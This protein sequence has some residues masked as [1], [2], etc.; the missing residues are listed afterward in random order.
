MTTNVAVRSDRVGVAIMQPLPRG[1]TGFNTTERVAGKQFAVAC[2]AVAR[3]ARANVEQFR[4]ADDAVTPSFHE[5]HLTFRDGSDGV[6]LI[7]N[8]HFPI[9]AFLAP[10][11][12]EGDA[13]LQFVDC[14]VV[15]NLLDSIFLVLNSSVARKAI[16][17]EVVANLDDDEM[18]QIQ[19][20]RPQSIGEIVFNYWDYSKT[21]ALR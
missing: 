2:H 12:F 17:A 5:A 11:R 20:W 4:S 18:K 19:Y 10:A 8:K 14:P 9:V 21:R 1:V 3:I 16:S 7:C 15:A 13:N 6:R